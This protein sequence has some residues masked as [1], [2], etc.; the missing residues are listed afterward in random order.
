MMDNQEEIATPLDNLPLDKLPWT[1]LDNQEEDDDIFNQTFINNPAS[2][3]RLVRSTPKRA[4]RR[5]PSRCRWC[6]QMMRSCKC[7]AKQH[8]TPTSIHPGR[9]KRILFRGKYYLKGLY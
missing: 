7:G 4:I 9:K 8:E 3:M 2:S 5:K 6:K 1:I